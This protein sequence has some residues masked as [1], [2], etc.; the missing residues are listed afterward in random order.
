MRD[1]GKADDEFE[2]ALAHGDKGAV[3]NADSGH[4]GKGGGPEH[5]ALGQQAHADGQN[6]EGAQLHQYTS[7]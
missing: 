2:V 1:G 3:D 7:V 5:G 6:A 4:D